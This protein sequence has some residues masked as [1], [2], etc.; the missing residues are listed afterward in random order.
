MSTSQRSHK[1]IKLPPLLV[2]GDVEVTDTS[3]VESSFL[4]RV[5]TVSRCQSQ[6]EKIGIDQDTMKLRRFPTLVARSEAG[7]V[8][9][10]RQAVMSQAWS[11]HALGMEANRFHAQT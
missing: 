3:D 10:L 1:A 11:F 8:S 2:D 7:Q 9:Q 5:R 4:T 6:P